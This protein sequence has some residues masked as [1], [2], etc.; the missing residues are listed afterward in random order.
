MTEFLWFVG[1]ALTYKILATLLRL[2]YVIIV[3]KEIQINAIKFL[4]TTVQEISFIHSLKYKT[5]AESNCSGEE[6]KAAKLVDKIEYAAWKKEVVRKL[7]SSV[8]PAIATSLS[9]KNWQ[10]VVD[11]LDHY[12]KNEK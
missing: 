6:I 12:Y 9:F 7:H 3:I 10:D 11:I 2:G 5:M 4:G 8:P 1:G